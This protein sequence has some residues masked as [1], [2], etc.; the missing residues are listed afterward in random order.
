MNTLNKYH[1]QGMRFIPGYYDFD[2]DDY[3]IEAVNEEEAWKEL[4]KMTK[5]FTWKSVG[6]THINGEK[7]E[8]NA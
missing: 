3:T 8:K 2:F 6:L 4:F 5:K 1:F 7:V